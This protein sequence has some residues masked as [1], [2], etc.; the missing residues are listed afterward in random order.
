MR[1]H[2]LLF[3]FL[4]CGISAYTQLLSGTKLPGNI[5]TI[6]INGKTV[7][8][9][10]ELDAGRT[11][12]LDVFATWCGP[13]WSFYESKVLEDLYREFGPSGTNTLSIYG[14]EGDDETTYE[15]LTNETDYS[16]GD[17]TEGVEYSIIDDHTFNNLLKI[18]GFPTIYLIRPDRTLL[19]V[20]YTMKED[21]AIWQS[22]LNGDKPDNAVFTD[23]NISPRVFCNSNNLP[24]V[25][26][27][28]IGSNPIGSVTLDLQKNGISNI[29]KYNL[30][31]PAKM[32]EVVDVTL[33]G[34]NITETTEINISLNEVDDTIIP[35]SDA[36]LIET[37]FYRPLI[38][39]NKLIVHFTTDYYPGEISWE[40]KDDKNRVLKTVQYREGNND[41]D[42]GGGPDANKTFIYEIDIQQSDINCMT[43][44]TTDSYGDGMLYFDNS[45]PVPGVKFYNGENELIK[46]VMYND[47]FFGTI[48]GGLEAKTET[49]VAAEI[50]S[51]LGGQ[52]F[53]Q[54]L[55]VYPN[56]VSDVLNIN[57]IIK[58]GTEYEVFIT[59]I[60]GSSFTKVS[61]NT[62]VLNVS[63]LSAGMYFLNIRTKEGVFAHKFTKI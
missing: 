37:T 38:R 25:S 56:P 19:E 57:M 17:W 30:S 33:D 13:C 62:N 32:F 2:L 40:L 36:T 50:T 41:P 9:Y 46:P 3:F 5:E 61:K 15:D 20:P 63:D 8:I 31:A 22:I 10:A 16:F 7:N 26:I 51:S 42:G 11:V 54:Q 12:I 21:L 44:T 58:G 28:N 29:K 52:D 4:T 1:Q 27:V 18:P 53:V 59:D 43:L 23:I 60:L 55:S 39:K 47:L 14:I 34:S 24:Y 48:E 6:D 45:D 35:A 49:Y